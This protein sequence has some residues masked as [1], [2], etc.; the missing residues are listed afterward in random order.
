LG[1]FAVPSLIVLVQTILTFLMLVYGLGIAVPNF[2]SFTL[3][4]FVAGQAFLA[5]VYL[6]LRALGEAGKL[7]VVLLLTLQL[8][9]GGGVMPIELT[10]GFFQTVH[11]WLPFTWVI[12]AFR[13]SLFGAY[14]QAWLHS[15]A[16]VILSG[17][18][19]LMLASFV[20]RWHTVA[21]DDYKPGIEV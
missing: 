15:L 2:L 4:M 12:K 8:A 6:L 20:R 13:G 19:A 16:D 14:D 10:G 18:L 11:D 3:S 9:A 5:I 1:R 17:V 7:L 21:A